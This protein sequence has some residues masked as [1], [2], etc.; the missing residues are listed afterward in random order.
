M[1]VYSKEN[2]TQISS[3]GQISGI[4]L[5]NQGIATSLDALSAGFAIDEY[6]VFC[7]SGRF[8]INSS[9]YI[10]NMYRRA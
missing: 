9:C 3:P 6:T 5:F 7:S 2:D 4:V 10:Y 8:F 1:I